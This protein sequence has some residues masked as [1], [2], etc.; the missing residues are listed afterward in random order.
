MVEL[1]A[2][3]VVVVLAAAAE[4]LHGLRMRRVAGLAFGPPGRPSLWARSA[5]AL[6]VSAFAMLAWGL[7]TLLLLEPKAHRHDDESD[8]HRRHLVIVL[9]VSPSMRLVDAGPEGDESRMHRARDV[10]DS[11]CDRVGSRQF[12]I[13]VVATYNGAIPVV[14]DS[15]DPEI[16]R[17]I[18]NDLPMHYAFHQGDTDLFAGL[19][20]AARIA[21]PWNPDSA[22][23]LLVSDGDTV[24]AT[25]MPKM[26]ASIAHKLVIGVGDPREGSFIDGRHS[27][28]EA[29]MLRQIAIRLGGLYHDGNTKQVSSDLL[30]AIAS[31]GEASAIDRLTRREY[32][33]I[34][35]ALGAFILAFLPLSLQLFGTAW[36]PGVPVVLGSEEERLRRPSRSSRTKEALRV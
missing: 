13:T 35:C 26:P 30:R 32:A 3:A 5:P 16:L 12:L 33:L 8:S 29:S 22:T 14:E 31:G 28:Q 9:D 11:M 20:E 19:E 1:L 18:L 2:T 4:S 21:H 34:A 36:T 7:A 10:L 23:L 27:R 24:P 25:G 17:N 6:R 15:R